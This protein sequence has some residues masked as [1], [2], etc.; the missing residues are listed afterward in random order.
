MSFAYANQ[1]NAEMVELKAKLAKYQEMNA[2]LQNTLWLA[3]KFNIT[4]KLNSVGFLGL[5]L[6]PNA[7][8]RNVFFYLIYLPKNRKI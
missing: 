1:G 7:Q 4:T 5:K 2:A 3:S 8:L 6:A